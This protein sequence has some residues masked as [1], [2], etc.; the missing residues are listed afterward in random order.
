[1]LEHGGEVLK[2]GVRRNDVAGRQVQPVK[3]V[4]LD[5]RERLHRLAH[6]SAH[7]AAAVGI[8]HGVVRRIVW[9]LAD[10]RRAATPVGPQHLE[11]KVRGSRSE[12]VNLV[13]RAPLFNRHQPEPLLVDVEVRLRRRRVAAR[14]VEVLLQRR[15]HARHRR[16]TRVRRGNRRHAL[17]LPPL[18]HPRHDRA[19]ADEPFAATRRARRGVPL[20]VLHHAHQ[21]ISLRH[22]IFLAHRVVPVGTLQLRVEAVRVHAVLGDHQRLV[23]HGVKPLKQTHGREVPASVQVHA[24]KVQVLHVPIGGFDPRRRA[25]RVLPDE[26]LFSRRE[27]DVRE[28]GAAQDALFLHRL[29]QIVDRP[30]EL[31][32]GVTKLALADPEVLREVLVAGEEVPRS[33]EL[34][35]DDPS[36]DRRVPRRANETLNLTLALLNRSRR[37]QH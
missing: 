16:Y 2:A 13:D 9:V 20:Q 24:P 5:P 27:V 12:Q 14:R 36:H 3:G 32:H 19:A 26:V 1:M 7:R 10:E 22:L 25:P 29:A 4:S 31:L 33:V 28:G 30:H 8:L 11:R 21:P 35:T 34:V 15:A 17:T 18:V 23:R 6:V 37:I